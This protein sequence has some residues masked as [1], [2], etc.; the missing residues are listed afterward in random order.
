MKT[1][2]TLYALFGTA[3]LSLSACSDFLEP[4]SQSEYVPKDANA[5]QEMLIGDAYPNAQNGGNLLGFLNVFDDDLQFCKLMDDGYAIDV[6]SQ[7]RAE[8][9]RAIFTWQ[10]DMFVLSKNNGIQIPNPWK[11][12]YELILGANAAL[13]YLDDV[14][15]TE[16]E[17]NYVRAQALTLRGFYYF[18]LVNL[19]GAPYNY[20]KEAL[21]V[22][23]KLS[24]ELNPDAEIFIPRNTVGEVYDQI[25][26][27]LNQAEALFLSLPVG[28]QYQP[29]YMVSL[30]MLELLKSRVCLY[31][32]NW[33]DAKKYAEKVINDWSFSLIDLN[34]LPAPSKAEPYYTFASIDKNPE[35]IWLY[36][37]INDFMSLCSSYVSKDETDWF[38]NK[39]TYN[40]DMF[41]ASDDLLNS[42]ENG[43]LRKDK[44]IVK[45]YESNSTSFID[46]SYTVYGKFKVSTTG[47]PDGSN[48]LALSFRL[49][50]AYLNLAEA[51]A[52][53][54]D[55]S[56]ALDAMKALLE[57]RYTSETFVAPTGLSGDEL[58]NYVRTE[59]RKEL[60]FEGQR[61]FDLRRYGM[62]QITHTW[63]G[64]TYT[65]QK[66]DAGY[67]MPIDEETLERNKALEQNPLPAKRE[68]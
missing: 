13:D 52:K 48:N 53:L 68:Y 30:P 43:D 56:T 64:Q 59:R 2:N 37:T 44:Y 23:L 50:E 32:N 31:M 7:S 3:L 1:K 51:A 19:Y 14:S 39:T 46:D 42:F 21:G 24:S 26:K 22:P 8:V 63:V 11:G 12:Y 47:A 61:W 17:K 33:T 16:E 35:V 55:S 29:D 5:L 40:R 27:D 57:K 45:E 66:N 9:T 58:V 6:N 54:G 36:G 60:C 10:P 65:L 67:T 49:S 4:K 38:G 25:L 18:T 15:G 41:I 62:P 20:N 28:K 34:T